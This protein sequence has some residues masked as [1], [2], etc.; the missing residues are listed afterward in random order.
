[1]SHS[2]RITHQ[3]TKI[4][5]LVEKLFVCYF[6]YVAQILGQCVAVLYLCCGRQTEKSQ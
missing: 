3:L 6:T 5:V 1:M 4:N 2:Y